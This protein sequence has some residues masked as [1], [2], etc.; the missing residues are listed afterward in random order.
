M[1]PYKETVSAFHRAI[2]LFVRATIGCYHTTH[3]RCNSNVCFVCVSAFTAW[4]AQLQCLHWDSGQAVW[5]DPTRS[6]SVRAPPWPLQD[7]CSG[8]EF[9]ELERIALWTWNR[10]SRHCHKVN[11]LA[12]ESCYKGTVHPKTEKWNPV[13]I[14]S[15]WC[16]WKCWVTF[17]S[18]RIPLE[19]NSGAAFSLRTEVDGDSHNL[20]NV[21]WLPLPISMGLRRS[22]LENIF[23][24]NFLYFFNQWLPSAGQTCKTPNPLMSENSNSSNRLKTFLPWT[25]THDDQY[26]PLYCS[27]WTMAAPKAMKQMWGPEQLITSCIRKVLWTWI[28]PLTLCWCLLRYRILSG[29]WRPSPQDFMESESYF[30]VLHA[31]NVI[32][33]PPHVSKVLD[34][35]KPRQREYFVIFINLNSVVLFVKPTK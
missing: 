32:I 18:P 31:V 1:S 25:D 28:T 14:S 34:T 10:F 29:S 8:G 15:P 17:Y 22:W 5:D 27:E 16:W 11:K 4:A 19:R 20:Q 21:K 7:L 35:E 9:C 26:I 30:Y 2:K 23:W 33:C 24:M 6:R 13:I 3:N 12:K